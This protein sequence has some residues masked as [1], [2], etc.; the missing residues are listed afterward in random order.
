LEILSPRA[1]S[2]REEEV[3]EMKS[4]CRR[5]WKN[6]KGTTGNGRDVLAVLGAILLLAGC[7]PVIDN[8][9]GDVPKGYVECRWSGNPG[10]PLRISLAQEGAPA[11][12]HT[13][14]GSGRIRFAARPGAYVL[15]VSSIGDAEILST[16]AKGNK[17]F[18]PLPANERETLEI[19]VWAGMKTLV[20]IDFE[21]QDSWSDW[22]GRPISGS[23]LMSLAGRAPGPK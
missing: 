20:D 22:I 17:P 10:F 14:E 8:L 16:V 15:E 7:A 12:Y 9:P 3:S 23:Y 21:R 1:D 4:G 6:R 11:V 19:Q 5:D 18:G 13:K 2:R